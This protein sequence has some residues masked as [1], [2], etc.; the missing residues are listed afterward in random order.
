[1]VEDDVVV[2]SVDDVMLLKV[3]RFSSSL[4]FL[5]ISDMTTYFLKTHASRETVIFMKPKNPENLYK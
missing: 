5:S 1:M 2:R 4:D 3:W